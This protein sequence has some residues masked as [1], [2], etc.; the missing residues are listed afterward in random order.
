MG[1]GYERMVAKMT[2]EELLLHARH[3]QT[4]QEELLMAVLNEAS[5][6]GLTIENKAAIESLIRQ[7]EDEA[8]HQAEVAELEKGRE[9]D[10]Q[11]EET[12]DPDSSKSLPV[13]YSQT[14]VLAFSLFFSP[15][16]G[17]ILLSINIRKL[18][19]KGAGQV[20]VFGLVLAIAQGIINMQVAPDSIISILAHVAGALLLSELM[21][22]QFIGRRIP[23]TRRNILIPLLIA[24]A[25]IAPLA[26]YLY[27]H[28]ELM[29]QLQ[30]GTYE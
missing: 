3:Y 8:R 18:Q 7:Y 17:S 23:Y 12:E 25:I 4:Y 16:A 9:D 20:L 11:V 10:Q 14:A 28:P 24:L 15:L 21:W 5:G 19:R 26:W 22:N 13:L 27:Q 29:E 2:D 6:R 30:N 1:N